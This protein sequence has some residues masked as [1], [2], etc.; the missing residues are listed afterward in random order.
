MTEIQKFSAA[1]M[2]SDWMK[3]ALSMKLLLT[4]TPTT[5]TTTKTTKTTVTKMMTMMTTKTTATTNTTKKK[6]LAV[7]I[8]SSGPT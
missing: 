6:A 1:K 4:G 8:C 3:Y 7:S 2:N 5:K